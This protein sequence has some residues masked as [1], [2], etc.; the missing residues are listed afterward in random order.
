MIY[1][2]TFDI[3]KNRRITNIMFHCE[4]RNAKEAV[5]IAR[6]AWIDKGRA[7]H[8]FH[9]YAHKSSIKTVDKLMVRAWTGCTY[10]G[11]NV[12]NRF[13]GTDFHMY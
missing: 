2:V 11:C 9:L 13:I 10:R 5:A 8:Q 12:M 7:E 4:A 6:Q 3:Q 1:Y